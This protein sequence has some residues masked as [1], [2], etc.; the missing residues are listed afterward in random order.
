MLVRRALAAACTAAAL[1]LLSLPIPMPGAHAQTNASTGRVTTDFVRVL[2]VD[3]FDSTRGTLIAA[4][5][6][7]GVNLDGQ[8]LTITNSS[9]S[10]ADFLVTT[11][12]RVCVDLAGS[13]LLDFAACNSQTSPTKVAFEAEVL[14]ESFLGLGTGETAASQVTSTASDLVSSRVIDPDALRFFSDNDQIA[15]QVATLAGFEALG[16]GGNSL[17]EIETFADVRIDVRYLVAGVE[18]E[19]LTNGG[20]GI[21]VNPGEPVEWTYDVTNTGNTAL[22]NVTVVDDLEGSIC[23]IDLLDAGTAR[24]CT[25]SGLAGSTNYANTATVTGEPVANPTALVTDTDDS[26][27]LVRQPTPT[28]VP[29]TPTPIPPAATPVP[30]AGPGN[31]DPAATVDPIA[32]NRPAIDIELATNGIDADQGPGVPLEV[33]DP[34]NWTYVVTNTGVVDLVDVLVSDDLDGGICRADFLPVGGQIEC[35][36]EG[37]VTTETPVYRRVSDVVAKSVDG[38]VVTDRDPTHHHIPDD[39]LGKVVRQPTADDPTD[40]SD[41]NTSRSGDPD[42]WGGPDGNVPQGNVPRGQVPSGDDPGP[43]GQSPDS[44]AARTPPSVPNSGLALT[45]LA[46][47]TTAMIALGLVA[48]GAGVIVTSRV[49]RR[50]AELDA[51]VR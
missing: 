22:Q 37:V 51:E 25:A 15:F 6:S 50:D 16:G 31:P 29:P 48:V 44:P 1:A 20:D 47:G 42:D 32:D 19:K 45:G 3:G 34:I 27:Y 23:V 12:A 26:N 11:S 43:N 36:K 30:T 33:G 35:V 49:R 46:S 9:S 18:I 5:L 14:A 2:S 10:P 24:Q 28:P 17:V 7:V 21:T 39:V 13:Q 41:P 38:Q 40:P 4:D 8:V